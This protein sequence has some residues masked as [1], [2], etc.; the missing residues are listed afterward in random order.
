MAIKFL[1]GFETYF[2]AYEQHLPSYAYPY[3]NY[4]EE[5]STAYAQSGKYGG[6][7]LMYSGGYTSSSSSRNHIYSTNKITTSES[8]YPTGVGTS[9]GD[10]TVG[11]RFKKIN[12]NS[13]A[14]T[15]DINYVSLI[16]LGGAA[17]GI[18][19][20]PT[21]ING[22]FYTP[23]ISTGSTSDND[24]VTYAFSN[25]EEW[26]YI[27]CAARSLNYT[28][29]N[30]NFI[31]KLD[32]KV[33]AQTTISTSVSI[34]YPLS[35]IT[36]SAT[37][38]AMML[39]DDLYVTDGNPKDNFGNPTIYTGFIPNA[40]R[41]HIKALMPT[42]DVST[43]WYPNSGST[44]YN[45]INSIPCDSGNTYISATGLYDIDSFQYQ[46]LNE[47]DGKILALQVAPV[48]QL[49][50]GIAAKTMPMINNYTFGTGIFANTLYWRDYACV[51]E[52]NPL[53]NQAWTSSDVSGLTAGIKM[54]SLTE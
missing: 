3:T 6:Y 2:S 30:Y 16:T 35:G 18:T 17:F 36:F 7:S 47:I 37:N 53:T 48:Q 42:G 54:T 26:H 19:I 1:E 33:V 14:I 10:L 28:S 13:I 23:A 38:I 50:M 43:Q 29:P 52:T 5:A 32:N 21:T 45:L 41:Y 8:Y 31:L 49:N 46:S 22:G 20:S 25:D 51:A 15:Y 39:I 34:S 4:S 27:E 44:H 12:S 11:F 24:Y 40:Y 9:L